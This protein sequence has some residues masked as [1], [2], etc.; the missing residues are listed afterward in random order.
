MSEED[1]LS[2]EASG[3]N[4]EEEEDDDEE[5]DDEEDEEDDED[6]DNSDDEDDDEDDEEEEEDDGSDDEEDE[7]DEESEGGTKIGK[8]KNKKDVPVK[9]DRG[10]I[11]NIIDEIDDLGWDLAAK[12]PAYNDKENLKRV[13]D[14]VN[15]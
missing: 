13:N 5:E 2:L 1:E 15:T 6:E 9:I 8:D 11:G 14:I 7:T 4:E 10:P 12:F 3:D